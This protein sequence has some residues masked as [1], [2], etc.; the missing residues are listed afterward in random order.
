[1]RV[2]TVG[3][4]AVGVYFTGRLAQSGVEVSVVARSDYEA[5]KSNGYDIHSIAGDFHFQPHAVLRSAADYPGEADF[6][7]FCGKTF[8]PALDMLRG[9]IRS[10]RTTIVLIQNGIGI[11]ET[12]AR[13]YPKNPLVSTVAYIGVS[14]PAPG[15]ILH[16]GSGNLTFGYYPARGITP[17]MTDLIE[18]FN[19]AKV[20][21]VW[22]D[23]I[24]YHRWKKLLWNI[25]YNPISV[26]GG[27][28]STRE[29][30]KADGAGKLCSQL[31]DE[32]I[33]VANAAG[34]PLRRADADAQIEYN[35][36]FP[37]YLTSMLQDFNA[38]RELE[39]EGIVGNVWRVAQKLGVA[40]PGIEFC[41]YLLRSVDR[42]NREKNR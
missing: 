29:M 11:E 35:E 15:K 1:M 14:R 31:M 40:T 30:C 34:V 42:K 33:S 23:D 17:E 41:Y 36:T 20:P 28:L 32:L 21:S 18:H 5:A 9:A 39:V 16:Q 3:A 25:S 8:A 24:Q 19:S 12:I 37:A 4:G 7:F 26:L 38:G 10:E 27:G 6:V 2:L 13:A 22:A